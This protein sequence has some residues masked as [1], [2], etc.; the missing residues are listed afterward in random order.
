MRKYAI[1]REPVPMN[2]YGD[3]IKKVML[4]S[5]KKD[6]T[7]IFLYSS[8]DEYGMCSADNYY[9]NLKFAEEEALDAYGIRD[10]DWIFIDDPLPNCQHDCIHPIR[11]KGRVD[12]NPI[13]GEYEIFNG[14]EWLDFIPDLR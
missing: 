7:Y 9:E 14:A 6:G 12:G 2:N 3:L 4:Y 1:L 5:D 10:E 11:V 8:T 13:W